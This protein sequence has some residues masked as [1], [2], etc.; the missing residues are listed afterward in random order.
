MYRTDKFRMG[1]D[2][3]E[4]WRQVYVENE[5]QVTDLT[6]KTVLDVGGHV[7]S[8][9]AKCID[10]GASLVV[11]VEPTPNT[12]DTYGKVLADGIREGKVR[13]VKAAAWTCNGVGK[14]VMYPNGEG[15]TSG[16]SLVMY[17]GDG[18]PCNL[19][20]INELISVHSPNVLKLD[21]EGAE[22]QIIES[23][24]LAD[25]I[26]TVLVEFHNVQSRYASEYA[27]SLSKMA[28]SGFAST[29]LKSADELRTHRFDRV[30]SIVLIVDISVHPGMCNDFIATASNARDGALTEPGCLR[31]DVM[32][33][34]S[35]P[36]RFALVEEWKSQEDLDNHR[37]TPHYKTWR[38]KIEKLQAMPRIHREFVQK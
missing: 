2:D 16:N 33:N 13:L 28:K 25:K 23:L 1:T 11:S 17:E 19:V 31:F 37:T 3:A 4:M 24:I 7:G 18:V 35:D 36:T 6:G 29:I 10:A 26:D 30:S 21:C 20:D 12:V 8:F 14:L 15:E 9:A 27:S 38:S 5:Y 32:E 34:V 22:Y